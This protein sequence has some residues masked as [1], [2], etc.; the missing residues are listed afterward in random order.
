MVDNQ[1]D[2]REKLF[3]FQFPHLFPNFK[4]SGPVDMTQDG[5]TK[6]AIK[7]TKPTIAQLRAQKRRGGAP[8]PEGRIG[9]LVVMKSGKVK[10]VLGDGI[11]MDVSA[12]QIISIAFASQSNVLV[13]F[14]LMLRP[15]Y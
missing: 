2:P 3:M 15:P 10:M 13:Q 8:P 14:R 5:D 9:T 7:D 12:C 4:A 6:E 11:V 1:D